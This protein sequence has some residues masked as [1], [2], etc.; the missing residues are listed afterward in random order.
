MREVG[1]D[2]PAPFD[3]GS[4]AEQQAAS[5][6]N[7]RERGLGTGNSINT[8]LTYTPLGSAR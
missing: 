1:L 8:K 5:F 3:I 6:K 7:A 4:I 2:V